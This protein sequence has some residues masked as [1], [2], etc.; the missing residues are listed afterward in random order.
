MGLISVKYVSLGRLRRVVGLTMAAES[1]FTF[2]RSIIDVRAEFGEQLLAVVHNAVHQFDVS[3]PVNSP[4]DI[5]AVGHGDLEFIGRRQH[6]VFTSS[7]V[8]SK[9]RFRLHTLTLMRLSLTTLRALVRKMSGH[10][11]WL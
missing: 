6:W 1:S 2:F 11:N 10:Q 3:C 9:L 8:P 4:K 5:Q 7:S